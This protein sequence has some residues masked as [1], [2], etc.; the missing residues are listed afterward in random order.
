MVLIGIKLPVSRDALAVLAAEPALPMRVADAELE[1]A[2]EAMADFTDVKSPY[3]IGHSRAVADLAGEAA[4]IFGLGDGAGKLVRRAG[5]VHDL[6][7]LGVSNAIWDK[8]GRL[9]HAETERV[10]LHPYLTERMQ[11]SSPALAHRI[12][13][14]SASLYAANHGLIADSSGPDGTSAG[15][16]RRAL[17]KRRRSATSRPGF[18]RAAK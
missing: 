18:S 9:S 8:P 1:A 3:T 15:S 14:H 11:A 16:Q 5:L 2:L 12:R 7:R 4:R 10:R 17:R 13:I 6:G